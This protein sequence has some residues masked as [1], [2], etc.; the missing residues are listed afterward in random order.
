VAVGPLLAATLASHDGDQ[1]FDAGTYRTFLAVNMQFAD[2]VIEVLSPDGG[3]LVIV[4]DYHPLVL[5]TFLRHKCPRA[6]VGFFLH[7]SFPSPEIFSTVPV[8]DDL[9][10]GLLNADLVSF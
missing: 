1:R 3:D 6:G 9:L 8:R 4:H 10:R 7:S 5:P 2:R